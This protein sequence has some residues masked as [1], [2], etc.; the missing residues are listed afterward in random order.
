MRRATAR[1][2]VDTLEQARSVAHSVREAGEEAEVGQAVD[3]IVKFLNGWLY[4]SLRRDEKEID[5]LF[6][7]IG[8]DRAIRVASWLARRAG[9]WDTFLFWERAEDR[10]HRARETAEEAASRLAALHDVPAADA[11]LVP[12]EVVKVVVS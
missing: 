5:D 7:T 6:A 3:S 12:V 9:D 11:R 10:F 8:Y 4:P 2:Q 1:T